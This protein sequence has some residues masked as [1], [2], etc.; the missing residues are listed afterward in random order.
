LVSANGKNLTDSF[1]KSGIG[2]VVVPDRDGNGE[3]GVA[4]NSVSQLDEVGFTEFGQLWRVREIS[5]QGN[6]DLPLWSITKGVQLG[7]LVGFMLLALP[8]SRG[9]KKQNQLSPFE[10][11][12]TEESE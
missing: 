7:V 11:L 3:L 2:Y 9:R 8:T 4:L 1:K 10:S 5:A 6:N 12:S